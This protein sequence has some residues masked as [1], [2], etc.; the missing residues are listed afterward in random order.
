VDGCYGNKMERL[1]I[2]KETI[3]RTEKHWFN[4]PIV[5]P[6]SMEQDYRALMKET[7]ARLS[8]LGCLPEPEWAVF[9][10]HSDDE[11]LWRSASP[12]SRILHEQLRRPDFAPPVDLDP[13][14]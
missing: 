12:L 13:L 10:D 3:L 2:E 8:L 6:V 11:Q 5:L 14:D 7:N 1:N 9:S 4:S